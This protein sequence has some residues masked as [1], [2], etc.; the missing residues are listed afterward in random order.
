MPVTHLVPGAPSL[1]QAALALLYSQLPAGQREQ[2]IA[3]TLAAVRRNELS[4]DN[5]VTA[6]DG[7]QV[8]GSVLAV[9]RPGGA[10]FLWPPAVRAGAAA[11]EVGTAL[12]SSVT[13]RMDAQGAQ[14]TQCLIEPADSATRGTLER[15]G[16]PYATDLVLLSRALV[17]DYSS[18]LA[19][20]L[21]VE[22][23]AER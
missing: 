3:E 19:P 6:L 21:S 7:D 13:S 10:A 1:Q 22:C 14:F 16:L 5:L 8:V 20:D 11:D 4:L 23:Y 12:L 2:Q 15:G 9:L 17:R 18:H